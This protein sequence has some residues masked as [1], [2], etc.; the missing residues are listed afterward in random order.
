MI[1]LSY[2][3]GFKIINF[4]GISCWSLVGV[5]LLLFF[6]FLILPENVLKADDFMLGAIHKKEICSISLKRLKSCCFTDSVLDYQKYKNEW[7]ILYFH[8]VDCNMQV[9]CRTKHL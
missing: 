7:G 3:F 9:H 4:Y 1:S 2:I 8:S 5:L 6:F